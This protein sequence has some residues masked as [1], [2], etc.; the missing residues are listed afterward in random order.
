MVIKLVGFLGLLRFIKR[1]GDRLLKAMD[2]RVIT[3]RVRWAASGRRRSVL[4]ELLVTAN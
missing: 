3:V 1:I 2:C 4:T